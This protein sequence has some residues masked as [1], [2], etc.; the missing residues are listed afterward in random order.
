MPVTFVY[1]QGLRGP[2]PQRW[3]GPPTNGAGVA[4]RSLQ[5]VELTD[6]YGELTLEQ[7][8]RLFPYKGTIDVA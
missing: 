2:E 7:L 6:A 3:H 4:R 8:T 5:S 1:V